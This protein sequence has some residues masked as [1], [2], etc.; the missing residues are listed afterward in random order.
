MSSDVKS[1]MKMPVSELSENRGLVPTQLKY[2]IKN[3]WF[4]KNLPCTRFSVHANSRAG[5]RAGKQ[6][7]SK[8]YDIDD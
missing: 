1:N 4:R 6:T 2:N 3:I 7:N 5:G 8:S